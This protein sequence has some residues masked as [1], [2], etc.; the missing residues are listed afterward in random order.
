MNNL[1][2]LK[3]KNTT[4]FFICILIL[5]AYNTYSQVVWHADPDSS[6][7]VNRFFQRFDTAQ[8]KTTGDCNPNGTSPAS[9]STTTDGEYGKVWKITKP[10]GR[11][12]A[13]LARTNGTSES[14]NHPNG[15][16]YYYGWRYKVNIAG[17]NVAATD[18]V[19][20]WQWKTES[21]GG[22]QNYP[23]NMEYS[24][25]KLSLEAWGPCVDANGKL[26]A[27]WSDCS[28]SIAQRRTILKT[29]SV[30]ENKWVDIVLKIKKGASGES[31][32]QSAGANGG[33]VEFWFNGVKQT[34][35]NSGANQYR[36]SLSSDKKKATHRTNDGPFNQAHNVYPKWGAYNGKA[37]K[38]SITSYFDEM[39]V[40]RTLKDASP[41]THNP[42]GSTSS[43]NTGSS[44]DV[45]GSWYRLRNVATNRYMDGQGED[46]KTTTSSSGNDKQFRFV[47]Q[48]SFYNIDI[49]KSS[50]TGRGIMRTV[51][52]NNRLKLTNLTPRNDG[53]KRYD[54]RRLSDG[55]YSIKSTNT[56][57]YLQNNTSNSV[58]LT[59]K[60]PSSNNRAKWRFI[61][62][63][64][65]K[66]FQQNKSVLEEGISIY[67]NPVSSDFN[68]SLNGIDSANIIITNVLGKVVYD[69]TVNTKNIKLSKSN[70][71]VSGIYILRAVDNKGNTHTQKFIVK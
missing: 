71:F 17:G 53:D 46:V 44:V 19:T 26:R 57:K 30:P 41:A 48:G 14:F 63:G 61:R 69:N 33:S 4:R 55:T 49:R 13:E 60:K 50:G 68:I 39:R 23:L 12:R 64:S 11:Q 3:K 43:G 10:K 58:T 28:G 7:N 24:N 52:S 6:T 54:I 8:S 35:G 21:P 36:V 56:D 59:V 22:Q 51:A 2:Y 45:S 15:S 1:N 9:V 47:K 34:L 20:I 66:S 18:K 25:G 32:G 5:T 38:Y 40:A 62:V 37:C 67:P 65:A 16:T 42:I 29:V 27:S 70:G 31:R